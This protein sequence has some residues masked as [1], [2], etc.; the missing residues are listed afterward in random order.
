MVKVTVSSSDIG[1][2]VHVPVEA[3]VPVTPEILTVEVSP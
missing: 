1:S 3:P 2:D